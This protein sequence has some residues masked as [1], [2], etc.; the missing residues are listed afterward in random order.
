[1]HEAHPKEGWRYAFLIVVLFAIAALAT[2]ET[3]NYIAPRVADGEVKIVTLLLCTLTLGLMLISGAFAVWSIRFASEAESLRRLG[4]L[5]DGMNYIRDGV[6]AIDPVGRITG[7]NPT[8]RELFNVAPN[9]TPHLQSICPTLSERD[10]EHLLNKSRP[11]EVECSYEAKAQPHTLRFRSQPTKGAILCIVSDVTKL[12]STRSRQRHAAY[13]QLV[14]H[15]AQGVANDFNDLLCGISGH[16]ALILRSTPDAKTRES[17]EAITGCANRG[18]HL[19]GRLIELSAHPKT[20]QMGSAPPAPHIEA[21]V[22]RLTADLPPTWSIFRNIDANM[23]S[24]DLTGTQLEH[25]THSLGLLAVDLYDKA[26]T[27]SVT[28]CL[29]QITEISHTPSGFSGFL[30]ITPAPM[31]SI[32]LSTLQPKRAETIGLIESIIISMLQQTNGLLDCFVTP[33]GIPLYRIGLPHATSEEAEPQAHELPLGL[34][35]YVANWHVLLSHDISKPSDLHSYL[36]ECRMTVERVDGIVDTLARIER[37]EDLAV[38][39]LNGDALGAESEG[40]LK[41]ILRL[42]P[43]AGL[44]IQQSKVPASHD[45]TTEAVFLTPDTQPTSWI[46]AMIDARSLARKRAMLSESAT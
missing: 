26:A 32:D 35:A 39:A 4:S 19:A 9:S 23:P 1:M 2:Q 41:A 15:I 29:P 34:E 17:V 31:D 7:L 18:I 3:I 12:T 24:A 45:L 44:V 16:A 14:G 30:I 38:I 20:L 8:A 10:I 13:L 22:D 25:I 27:L 46:R 11:E 28:L 5:V 43:H 33:D 6:L 21:A 36:K 40:L 42:C 37:G